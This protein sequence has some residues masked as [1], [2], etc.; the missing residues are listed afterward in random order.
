MLY[1]DKDWDAVAR[2]QVE[3]ECRTDPNQ[4][5]YWP[6]YWAGERRYKKLIRMILESPAFD[7]KDSVCK[8]W[9]DGGLS[10]RADFGGNERLKST[11]N[12]LRVGVANTR[13]ALA[14]SAYSHAWLRKDAEMVRFICQFPPM[15]FLIHPSR[16]VLDDKVNSWTMSIY[17]REKAIKTYEDTLEE[18]KFCMNFIVLKS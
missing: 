7:T 5:F 13:Y 6:L 17:D 8:K 15:R 18:Y 10:K 14:K 16:R 11:H 3:R 9:E 4:N 2:A 1:V 12:S